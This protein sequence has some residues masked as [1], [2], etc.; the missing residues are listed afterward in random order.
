MVASDARADLARAVS[1]HGHLCA[2]LTI[3]VRAAR[4]ALRELGPNE[5]GSAL[6]AIVETAMCPTDAIQVLTG[7]TFGRGTLLHLDHGKS[8]FTFVRRADGYALRLAARSEGWPPD[9]P[10]RQLLQ[11]QIQAGTAGPEVYARHQALLDERAL[12]LLEVPEAQLFDLR[13]VVPP[14][15][16]APRPLTQARCAACGEPV[17][18][19]HMRRSGDRDLCAPCAA[20]EGC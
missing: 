1:F 11:Q 2:G 3:G 18:A 15:L 17:L 6:Y 12:A 8:V 5:A 14:L 19:S 16:A 10:E 7:C 4:I 13:A 9:H 20:T